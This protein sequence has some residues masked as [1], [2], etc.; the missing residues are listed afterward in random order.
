MG[1][2]RS[3]GY[4]L[5]AHVNFHAV[6][7][8]FWFS[9]YIYIPLFSVYLELLQFSYSMI[10]TILGAYG[11]TQILFRL[12]LGVMTDYLHRSRKM[13]ILLSFVCAFVSCML[14]IYFT[15]F[16]LVLLA[17]LLA[18]VT[19]SMWVLVTVMYT[20][21]FAPGESARSMGAVQFNMVVT[22][23]VC[24]SV[25]GVLIAYLG[26][27]FPFVLGAIAALVGVVLSW[28]LREVNVE[29]S[30]ARSFDFIRAV[31][32]T[33][34][35]KGLK[36]LT[37]LSLIAHAMLFITVFGFS[38]VLA[39]SIGVTEAQF[40]WLMGAFFIPHALTS[41]LLVVY[42]FE[43]RYHMPV[44]I[45]SFL[46][47]I[48]FLGII[49]LANSLLTISLYHA[50]L[51]FFLGFT[52]PLILS[53]VVRVSPEQLKMSAMGYYQSFYA[54]GILLGPLVA[55]MI[56]DYFGL[57]AIFYLSAFASFLLVIPVLLR[58]YITRRRVA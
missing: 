21:Y 54:I 8:C 35:I 41:F 33:N 14:M 23:F 55:G 30:A 28:N 52:F 32:E 5:G 34:R 56:G 1:L 4:S 19:A 31:K 9:I 37:F 24:M 50:G 13:L 42:P 12:P 44:L 20:Y 48:L 6:V 49:P 26:W 15:H 53:E 43:Q 39:T 51:G 2:I 27:R 29:K 11:V 38:P 3:G 22:Q 18:G 46:L 36:V 40:I 47:S 16:I 10:G 45:G 25:S 7:F 17:R 57:R 58:M